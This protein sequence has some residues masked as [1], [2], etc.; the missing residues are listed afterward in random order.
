[1]ITFNIYYL[2]TYKNTCNL[3]KK[4]IKGHYMTNYKY[5]SV[6]LIDNQFV[7]KLDEVHSVEFLVNGYNNVIEINPDG[8]LQTTEEME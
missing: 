1:M 3:I 5:G 7:A 6:L 4:T 8:I 2:K